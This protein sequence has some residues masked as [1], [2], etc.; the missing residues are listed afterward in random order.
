MEENERS[1]TSPPEAIY[2]ATTPPGQ[3]E[4]DEEALAKSRD[5]LELAAGAH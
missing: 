3:G 2:E 5:R 1:T 4:L